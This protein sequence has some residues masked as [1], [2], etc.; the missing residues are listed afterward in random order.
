[1]LLKCIAFC[2]SAAKANFLYRYIHTWLIKVILILCA[3]F[4]KGVVAKTLQKEQ[5]QKVKQ[6]DTKFHYYFDLIRG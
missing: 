4:K 3:T 5:I 2:I 1:M 6:K